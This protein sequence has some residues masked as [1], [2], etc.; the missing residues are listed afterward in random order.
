MNQLTPTAANGSF[1]VKDYNVAARSTA[2]Y[3]RD[4][5]D[6]S[7][8]QQAHALNSLRQQQTANVLV[9]K[10]LEDIKTGNLRTKRLLKRAEKAKCLPVVIKILLA[11][12]PKTKVA[13]CI[14]DVG[15]RLEEWTTGIIRILHERLVSKSTSYSQLLTS[16]DCDH[17]LHTLTGM[18]THQYRE[19]SQYLLDA[20]F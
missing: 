2:Q 9:L 16:K 6:K 13:Q 12:A 5:S 15:D 3:L 17:V 20:C 8:S 7:Q 10:L 14:A 18:H 19:Y 1:K 11:G 4:F